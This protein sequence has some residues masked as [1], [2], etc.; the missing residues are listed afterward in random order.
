MPIA[1]AAY[2]RSRCLLPSIF[3]STGRYTINQGNDYSPF[4]DL[5]AEIRASLVSERVGPIGFDVSINNNYTSY[6]ILNQSFTVKG[7]I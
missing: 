1:G 3:R 5:N 7:G 6:R 4:F 2:K